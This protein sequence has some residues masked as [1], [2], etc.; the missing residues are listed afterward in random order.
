M[1]TCSNCGHWS[2][3]HSPVDGR[4]LNVGCDC[5]QFVEIDE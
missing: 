3:R 4:C 1:K 2:F 5:P